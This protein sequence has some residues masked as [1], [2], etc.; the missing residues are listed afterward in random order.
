MID[1]PLLDWPLGLT[2]IALAFDPEQQPAPES[3]QG[4]GPGWLVERHES[5]HGWMCEPI[6]HYP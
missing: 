5:S 1:F 4:G 3:D 6:P 2:P